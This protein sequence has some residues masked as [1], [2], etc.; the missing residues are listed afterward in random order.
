M[1]TRVIALTGLGGTV[2]AA[3]FAVPAS[4]D[5]LLA[6]ADA[7]SGAVARADDDAGSS[8][9]QT[10]GATG[11]PGTTDREETRATPLPVAAVVV[12]RGPFVQSVRATGRAE[13]PRRVE[14]SPRVTERIMAVHVTEG[15]HVER[16]DVL[17]TLDARPF[18]IARREAEA[19]HATAEA[20]NRVALFDDDDADSSRRAL[21]KH[22]SGLTQAEQSVARARLDLEH[23]RITAPFAG[24]IA[25]V[26]AA[27][28]AQAQVGRAVVTLVDLDEIRVPAEVLESEFGA[29]VPGAAARVRV[30][31]FPDHVYAGRVTALGPEL[32]PARGTGTAYVAVENADHRIRPGMYAE[33]EI[34]AARHE[35]RI[36]VPRRAVLER[37][38]K[39]LVFRAAN[40]RAEW[41]Y[42]ETGLESETRVEITRGLSPGDSVLV[43]GHLTL[44]H[45]AP[46]HVKLV[47][48]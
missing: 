34:E 36:S 6:L 44:A 7:R 31:A 22:R 17:L 29:L 1:K 26:D 47:E 32:D 12:T 43:D 19:K 15:D 45:G 33:V 14:L 2:V 11:A 13:A 21:A 37:D 18:E 42:V 9:A 25:D 16:G 3:L 38:R 27:V 30:A 41:Q 5:A 48:E 28:G 8:D 23:T 39:L 46:V 20:D 35:N 10:S 4:R 24:E 40:G